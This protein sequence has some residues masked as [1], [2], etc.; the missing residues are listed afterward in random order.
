MKG[1]VDELVASAVT[2]E[3]SWIL[4][5]KEF[6]FMFVLLNTVTSWAT[7]NADISTI[8]IRVATPPAT[9][10]TEGEPLT[11]QNLLSG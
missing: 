11:L 2:V 8:T 9:L 5:D 1:L 6:T 10:L 4:W 7:A 3:F